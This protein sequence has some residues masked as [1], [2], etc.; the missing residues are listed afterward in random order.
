MA[1]LEFLENVCDRLHALER[2]S[3]DPREMTYACV[4]DAISRKRHRGDLTLKKTLK[5]LD[6]L[7]R[8]CTLREQLAPE[9]LMDRI[10]T[11][12]TIPFDVYRVSTM[13]IGYSPHLVLKE[14][15]ICQQAVGIVRMDLPE[16]IRLDVLVCGYNI[17]IMVSFQ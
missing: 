4:K 14:F 17:D 5:D 6:L 11:F 9:K 13:A 12:G 8:V 10:E 16:W 1:E 7:K 2:A 15:A 3:D